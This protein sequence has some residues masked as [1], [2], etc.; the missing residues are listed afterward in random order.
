MHRLREDTPSLRP[1]DLLGCCGRGLVSAAINLA[2][3]GLP[4]FGLSHVMIVG[5][6]LDKAEMAGWDYCDCTACLLERLQHPPLIWESTTLCDLP[7]AIHHRACDG[8]QAHGIAGRLQSYRGRIWHYPLTSPLGPLQLRHLQCFLFQ[9]KDDP[10]DAIGAFR[11]RDTLFGILERRL[12]RENLH[13]L[14]CS[15]FAA[16]AW[17]AAGVWHAPDVRLNPNRLARLA[18]A[19]GIV[20]YPTEI[21]HFFQEQ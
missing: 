12:F 8:V 20:D 18:V 1:G 16:A 11:A 7:C 21:T 15:E 10:Y 4:G 3:W 17:R 14:Y 2:T 13:S 6:S 19:A 5:P 9:H